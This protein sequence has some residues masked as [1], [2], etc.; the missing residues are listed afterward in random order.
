MVLCC[1]P[2]RENS[3]ESNFV[4]ISSEHKIEPND[5]PLSLPL[6]NNNEKGFIV[7]MSHMLY[8]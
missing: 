5:I 4:W 8:L 6:I 1:A 3:L 2:A 7:I